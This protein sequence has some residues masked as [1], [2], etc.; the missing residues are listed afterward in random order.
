MTKNFALLALLIPIA[1]CTQF[2]AREEK[3]VYTVKEPFNTRDFAW[4]MNQGSA[5]IAGRA[6]LKGRDGKLRT[7]AGNV[8]A[9]TADNA[10]SREGAAAA[11]THK[12]S[13]IERDPRYA[14]YRRTTM[15]DSTGRFSF[16]HL[17][18]GNWGIGTRVEWEETG[19][20]GRVVRGG[21]LGKTF[22]LRAGENA[23]VVLDED[24]L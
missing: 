12:Y 10:Y 24:D 14:N 13:R 2:A 11:K 1:A 9:L 8:V 23:T 4:S 20:E 6:M 15:C 21:P 5:Q 3:G 7:C 18:H 19:P 17:P 16:R 22:R